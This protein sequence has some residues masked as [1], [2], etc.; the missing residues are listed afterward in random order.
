MRD[1]EQGGGE[2]VGLRGL[3]LGVLLFPAVLQKAL[4]VAQTLLSGSGGEEG[5]A[6]GRGPRG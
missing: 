3:P 5:R 4:E 1:V 6:G 2:Q